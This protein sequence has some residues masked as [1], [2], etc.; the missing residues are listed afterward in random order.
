MGNLRKQDLS[1]HGAIW[2]FKCICIYLYMGLNH[3]KSVWIQRRY[4][5]IDKW[6]ERD[7]LRVAW[8]SR[9]FNGEFYH[10]TY[11]IV[12]T[13]LFWSGKIKELTNRIIQ[14]SFSMSRPQETLPSKDFSK[15]P[16]S[17][18]QRFPVTRP[19]Y[20]G[21]IQTS[22]QSDSKILK[23]AWLLALGSALDPGDQHPN[24]WKT[25]TVHTLWWRMIEIYRFIQISPTRPTHRLC[26]SRKRW[27][28]H[29]FLWIGSNSLAKIKCD[30]QTNQHYPGVWSRSR[31]LSPP[32]K[33]TT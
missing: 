19:G 28:R 21:Y 22:T 12:S 1:A 3:A 6:V 26:H 16:L 15:V 8:H 23:T 27:K 4:F 33:M 20:S 32:N 9:Q 29:K 18:W 24:G 13:W 11:P 31:D 2:L 17:S 10:S 14:H 25:S 5:C 30:P 7:G